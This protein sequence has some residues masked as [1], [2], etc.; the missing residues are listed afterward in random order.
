MKKNQK[1]DEI[2]AGYDLSS[3]F[4]NRDDVDT[5]AHA[6]ETYLDEHGKEL[7]QKQYKAVKILLIKL[8]DLYMMW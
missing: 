8:N 5:C 6:V 2:P 1:I 3:I 4:Q 7:N